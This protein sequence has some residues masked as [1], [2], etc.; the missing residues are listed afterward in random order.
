MK[1]GYVYVVRSPSGNRKIGQTRNVRRR[2]AD[3][4][5]EN[6]L[7]ERGDFVVEHFREC[8]AILAT[9]IETHAHALV[10]VNRIKG[11]W[12]DIDFESAKKAVDRAIHVAET[13]RKFL[14]TLK[15][16]SGWVSF[17]A[18]AYA[19]LEEYRVANHYP[20]IADAVRE[21]IR[22]GRVDLINLQA[23]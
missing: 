9:A 10:W 11:D 19:K 17:P 15:L 1:V 8:S 16:T 13:D 18:C 23:K 21:L 7:R 2:L 4:K 5:R 6:A 22:L 14:S 20:T 3:I 12:F